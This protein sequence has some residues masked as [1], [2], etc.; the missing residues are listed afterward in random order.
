MALVTSVVAGVAVE[1]L[2]NTPSS[3]LEKPRFFDDVGDTRPA[4]FTE[5]S[6]VDAVP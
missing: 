3:R 1:R 5:A 4:L 2:E 6:L